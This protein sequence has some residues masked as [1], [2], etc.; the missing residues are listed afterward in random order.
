MIKLLGST[1]MRPSPLAGVD[2]DFSD[3]TQKAQL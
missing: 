2:E 1:L 3:R